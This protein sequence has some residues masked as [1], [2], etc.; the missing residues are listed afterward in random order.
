[1]TKVME[2]RLGEC[3]VKRRIWRGMGQWWGGSR[4]REKKK[5]LSHHRYELRYPLC[6]GVK[7]EIS[8]II[9][10]T[11]GRQKRVLLRGRAREFFCSTSSF[12][13]S[14]VEVK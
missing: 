7:G 14:P 8:Q 1:M 13:N 12:Q 6:I 2:F 4:S 10:K 3:K 11:K 9:N 5:R